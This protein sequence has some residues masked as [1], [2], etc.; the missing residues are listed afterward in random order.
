MY[1]GMSWG[2]GKT[3]CYLVLGNTVY[4]LVVVTTCPKVGIEMDAW[5]WFSH[6][7]IWGSIALWF[8]FLGVYSHIWPGAQFVASNM[9]GMVQIL[10]SSPVFWFRLLLVPVHHRDGQDQDS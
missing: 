7:N 3:Y 2:S 5:T 1:Y 8:F 10:L 4:T 9:A 6:G